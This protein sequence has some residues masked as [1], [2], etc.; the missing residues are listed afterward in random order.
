MLMA[1]VSLD[2]SGKQEIK[3]IANQMAGQPEL[4]T[5]DFNFKSKFEEQAQINKQNLFRERQVDSIQELIYGKPKEDKQNAIYAGDSVL[6]FDSFRFDVNPLK[7]EQYAQKD[8]KRLLKKKFVTGQNKDKILQNLLNMS[9][10][11]EEGHDKQGDNLDKDQLRRMEGNARK[12]TK[13][14]K[15][16]KRMEN[17]GIKVD[18]DSDENSLDVDEE[19]GEEE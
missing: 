15:K 16:R 12:G 18:T 3:S 14:D 1:G 17:K 6:E 19:S 10:S 8:Y 4:M 11:D 5:T 13:F 9:D 2:Y 7:L